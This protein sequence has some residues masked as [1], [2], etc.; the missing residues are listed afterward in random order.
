MGTSM[1]VPSPSEMLVRCQVHAFPPTP[2]R[3]AHNENTRRARESGAVTKP[4]VR[5]NQ[6]GTSSL[7]RVVWNDKNQIAIPSK[8]RLNR[9][10]A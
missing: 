7:A 1:I 3:R 9:I 8:V 5:I 2:I 10:T 6:A 4:T